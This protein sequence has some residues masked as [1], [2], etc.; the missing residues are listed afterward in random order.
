[1]TADPLKTLKPGQKVTG[2]VAKITDFGIFI[3]L[4]SGIEGLV[5]ASEIHHGKSMFSDSS[6]RNEKQEITYKEG[7]TVSAA[8]LKVNKKDRKLELSI[9]RYEQDQERELLRKYS[10]S[11]KLTLGETT[12]WDI[13]PKE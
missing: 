12:G 4:D 13:E 10:Q 6:D 5:R 11:T 9:R 8:V 7:E 1:M 3:K 2:T